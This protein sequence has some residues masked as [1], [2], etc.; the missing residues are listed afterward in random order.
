MIHFG[1]AGWLY[2]DWEGI[3]YPAPKPKHFDPLEYLAR[4]FTT[5]EINST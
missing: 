1:T 5:V 2:K 4:F 3:V